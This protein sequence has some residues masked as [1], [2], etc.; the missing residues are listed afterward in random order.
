MS[1][2]GKQELS[3]SCLKNFFYLSTY[4]TYVWLL[5]VT[6]VWLLCVIFSLNGIAI[7]NC[8]FT[9]MGCLFG[10]IK[11]FLQP[12]FHPNKIKDNCL[13]KILSEVRKSQKF[14]T[15]ILYPLKKTISEL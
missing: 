7:P 3:R 2:R 4:V 15:P 14:Q 1:V 8:G 10:I 11:E 6:Y 9:K 5:C 13:I 12:F